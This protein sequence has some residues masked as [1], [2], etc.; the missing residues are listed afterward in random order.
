MMML[1]IMMST[2]FMFMK[3][4]MSSGMILL[5]Q[6][7][8]VSLM[9]GIMVNNFWFSYILILSM[10]SGMLVLF[11][12][13]SSIASNEKFKT[14]TMMHAISFM[15]MSM[16]LMVIF[17][18]EQVKTSKITNMKEML[19]LN[20]EMILTL[21]KFFNTYNMMMTILLVSFLLYTMMVI[22]FIVNIY[23]GP[24]RNKN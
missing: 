8:M 19:S 24:L 5:M 6:T 20:N 18:V 7:M 1:S 21:V 9:T 11:I 13:M 14:P 12:Y 10:M 15:L 16:L 22:N 2:L 23:E 17:L 4:P 3:H